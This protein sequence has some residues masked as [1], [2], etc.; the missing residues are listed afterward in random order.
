MFGRRRFATRDESKNSFILA[1][2]TMGEGWHNNHHRYPVSA[3][4]GFY[5]WEID[6]TYYML[7]LLEK[8]GIVWGLNR[9]PEKIYEEAAGMKRSI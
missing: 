7:K 2:L 1:L 4:Q 3:R 8:L 5:W 9:P 6:V